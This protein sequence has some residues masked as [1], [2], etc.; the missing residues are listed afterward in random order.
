MVALVS[1]YAEGLQELYVRVGEGDGAR[2]LRSDSW[3]ACRKA[4]LQRGP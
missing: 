1:T 3:R 2:W 4:Q